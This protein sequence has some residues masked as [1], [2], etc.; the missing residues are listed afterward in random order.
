[1]D[2]I[3][4]MF[5][6]DNALSDRTAAAKLSALRAAL[7]NGDTSALDTRQKALADRIGQAAQKIDS[8]AE[9][10]RI[11]ELMTLAQFGPASI[12]AAIADACGDAPAEPVAETL[13]VARFLVELVFA[14]SASPGLVPGDVLKEHH[15]DR[16]DISA[17]AAN[18]VYQALLTRAAETLDRAEGSG[19]S[20]TSPALRKMLVRHRM[21]TRRQIDRLRD[22]D[23]A[24]SGVRLTGLDN[25]MISLKLLLRLRGAS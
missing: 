21:Q 14:A 20:I 22:R 1:M 3:A 4:D 16:A 24:S 23:P 5:P 13:F 11:S 12:G 19:V 10:A 15:L 6:A 2:L 18:P 17:P 7:V 9:I 25:L 8:A